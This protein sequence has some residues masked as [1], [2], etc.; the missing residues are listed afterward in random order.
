MSNYNVISGIQS[1]DVLK[2]AN[3]KRTATVIQSAHKRGRF[4]YIVEI[5]DI[6]GTYNDFLTWGQLEARFP[7][8]VE[9]NRYTVT[10]TDLTEDELA[11]VKAVLARRQFA[12]AKI[13]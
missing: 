11:E 6:Q 4:G 1:G 3:G 12:I 9:N 8:K 2:N 7:A 5:T 10:L 13:A